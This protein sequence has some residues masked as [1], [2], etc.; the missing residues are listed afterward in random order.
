[1]SIIIQN[2]EEGNLSDYIKFNES[3]VT[4]SSGKLIINYSTTSAYIYMFLL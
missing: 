4:R 1:M 3:A 2:K